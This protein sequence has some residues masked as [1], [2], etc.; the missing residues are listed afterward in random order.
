MSRLVLV[1]AADLDLDAPFEGIGRTPAPIATVLRD[2]SLDAWEHLVQLALAR[3][4]DALLLSGG[5]AGDLERGARAHA[6]LRDGL[7]RL[8]EGGVPVCIALGARDPAD[9]FAAMDEWPPQVTRFARGHSGQMVLTR[10]GVP[11]ATVHG[12]SSAIGQGAAERVARLGRP[13]APGL[14]IGMLHAGLAD[15]SGLPD[16][17]SARLADLEAAR[18][19]YWA[20]G[21]ARAF[22]AL[23]RGPAWVVYPGTPQGRGLA[24]DECGIK[25][26]VVVEAEGTAITRVEL[27]PLDRVRCLRV[28]LRDVDDAAAL[29]PALT[30]EAE[31][32]RDRHAGRALVLEARVDGPASIQRALRRPDACAELLRGLRRAADSWD[33]F[34]WWAR[35]RPAAVRGGGFGAEQPD[36][37]AA[38]VMRRRAVLAAD[39]AATAH[40]VAHRFAPLRDAWIADLEPRDGEEVL[41]DAAALAVTAV[42]RDEP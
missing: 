6:R 5:L 18:L 14:H 12:I 42:R 1:H 23:R 36:D 28:D 37:L 2:A 35:V 7:K 32:L 17:A 25:G 10:D 9:G 41:D 3:R 27:E 24:E 39:P 16:A 33:P 8:A 31:R 15:L 38:E 19:D 30:A 29:A 13:S 26:A 22:T 11:A 34:V 21:Q 40:F 4:A 20:L